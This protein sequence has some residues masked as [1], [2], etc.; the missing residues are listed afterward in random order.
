MFKKHFI[1]ILST[2]DPSFPMKLWCRLIPHAVSTLNL[3]RTYNINP[4]L[5]AETQLNGKF[6]YN[7]TP[8]A[9]A[10]TTVVAHKNTSQRGSWTIHGAI[11]WYL[12]PATNHYR[13][14]E[15]YITN[16]GQTRIVDTV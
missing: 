5:S 1:A 11:V 13:L 12:G 10:R 3:L 16:T 2:T 7:I 4:K 9:P 14:F 8:L 6:D 15:V